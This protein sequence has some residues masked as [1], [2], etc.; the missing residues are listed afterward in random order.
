MD[1][2]D[3]AQEHYERTLGYEVAA[4]RRFRPAAEPIGTCHN[5]GQ[6]VDA[7][8]RWCDVECRAD[9]EQRRARSK[10]AA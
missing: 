5:C 2:M 4:A 6:D 8:L 10:V 3:R 7:G 1:E 9:W